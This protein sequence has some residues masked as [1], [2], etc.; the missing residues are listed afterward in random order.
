MF[1]LGGVVAEVIGAVAFRVDP[2]TDV[3]AE[4][5][6]A[7]VKTATLLQGYRGRPPAD[8]R[9]LLA[10]LL[11]VS[12]LVEDMPEIDEIDITP[13]MV[14]NDGQGAIAL[15]ARIRLRGGET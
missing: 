5:L 2:L 13:V 8:V 6:I 14:R 9:A 10:L 3:D 4:E 7:S 1:G 15:D 12:R 11:R